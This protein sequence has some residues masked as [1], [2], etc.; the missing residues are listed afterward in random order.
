MSQRGSVSFLAKINDGFHSQLDSSTGD[1]QTL[2]F[3]I[4]NLSFLDSNETL[5]QPKTQFY[6]IDFEEP[7][8]HHIDIGFPENFTPSAL[9]F[10]LGIDSAT[11]V[12]GVMG[13]ALDPMKGMYWTWQ[14]GYINFKIET[15][16]LIY[17]I[18]GYSPP[19]NCAREI[20]IE[21]IG[22]SSTI[23]IDIDALLADRP[24]DAPTNIMSPNIFAVNVANKLSTLF[25]LIK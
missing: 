12:A 25:F 21:N 5:F 13:E 11:N 16:Q 4:S 2:K 6:L 23:G 14:S 15:P 17:H 8:I 22:L 24:A 1:I 3:Y 9:Q 7:S 18:G 20:S 10:T 19:F